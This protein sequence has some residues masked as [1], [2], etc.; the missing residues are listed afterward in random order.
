MLRETDGTI[1]ANEFMTQPLTDNISGLETEVEQL[2]LKLVPS[3]ESIGYALYSPSSLAG[4]NLR[5]WI[6][7]TEEFTHQYP[8]TPHNLKLTEQWSDV[9]DQIEPKETAA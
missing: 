7:R 9:V 8:D 2:L 5:E 6:T 3:P 4:R 1:Q